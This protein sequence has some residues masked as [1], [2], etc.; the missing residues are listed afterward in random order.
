ME[1]NI[2]EYRYLFNEQSIQIGSDYYLNISSTITLDYFNKLIQEVFFWG[3]DTL[4]N[5]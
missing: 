1:N 5:E 2:V 3:N 4:N